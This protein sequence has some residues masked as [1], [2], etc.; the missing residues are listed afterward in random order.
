MASGLNQNGIPLATL[1][2]DSY[3]QWDFAG[4]VDLAKV[5]AK[6]RLPELT[7]DVQNIT[8]AKQRSFF[9]F[10][11]AAFTDYNPGRL[12]LIGLRGHF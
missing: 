4:S 3:G 7:L 2:S 6:P 5:F 11:D 8:K 1:N 12:I 10:E 9:Q